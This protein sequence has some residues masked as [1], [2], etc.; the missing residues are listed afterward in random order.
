MQYQEFIYPAI[1]FV[2]IILITWLVAWLFNLVFVGWYKIGMSLIR[3]HVQR[4]ATIVIWTVGLILAI[5]QFGLDIN[6]LLLLIGILGVGAILAA[7]DVL[8]N[9][10]AK[11]FSD[12]YIPFKM[13]DTIRIREHSGKVIEINPV[14]TVL[15]TE[16]DE[17]IS[18]PNSLFI[19]EATVNITPQAWKEI[20]IPIAFSGHAEVPEFETRVIR[21]I[22]K[23]KL[24]MDERFP[25]VMTVKK[26]EQNYFEAVLTLMIKDPSRKD[27]ITSKIN[28]IITEVSAELKG[29]HHKKD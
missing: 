16:K 2:V 28:N 23:F 14:A 29:K 4:V 12:V 5:E 19:K 25:P 27:E 17:L 20:I 6:L 11:Y 26:R 13:G 3:L 18:I 21:A 8:Q 22:N 24:H 15:L 1:K 9:L 7:R 10:A